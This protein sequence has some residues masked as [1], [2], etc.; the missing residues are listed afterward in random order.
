MNWIENPQFKVALVWGAVGALAT[1]GVILPFVPALHIDGMNGG[2]AVACF[3]GFV[4][5]CCGI[6]A[7]VY[8]FRAYTLN[9]ILKGDGVL[10]RWSFSPEEW[11]RFVEA[12]HGR[13][14]AAKL[15]TF[16]II[17][18]FALFFGLLFL[19]LGGKGGRATFLAMLTLIAFIGGVAALSVA[20]SYRANKSSLGEVIVARTGIYL[21]RTL[22]NWNMLGARLDKVSLMEAEDLLLEFDYS[23]P[24]RAGRQTA[25]VR[26]PVPPGR[27][28]EAARL[29]AYFVEGVPFEPQR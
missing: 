7:M 18:G 15:A 26:F 3:S 23:Y 5:M 11:S 16:Y 1:L 14:R 27:E 25:E 13:D 8:L 29:V 20:L 10:V 17:A 22:H 12:E 24:A 28:A 2:F 21:N 9:G 19:I 6:G 4:A